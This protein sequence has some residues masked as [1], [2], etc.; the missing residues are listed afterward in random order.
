MAMAMAVAMVVH[1]FAGVRVHVRA[2]VRGDVFMGR[3]FDNEDDFVRMDF[4]LGE[5]SSSAPWVAQVR[6]L[7][8]AA[9]WAAPP[10]LSRP[11]G[12]QGRAREEG[13]GCTSTCTRTMKM[14]AV[15]GARTRQMDHAWR[16]SCM[17]W[18]C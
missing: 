8:C 13:P 16:A 12:G 17:A 3:I 11:A 6:S 14:R 18:H 5:V 4:R 7:R 10:P 15:P 2:Q 9:L 1:V